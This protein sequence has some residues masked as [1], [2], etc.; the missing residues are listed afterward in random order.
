M[1]IAM[2]LIQADEMVQQQQAYKVQERRN[3]VQAEFEL[4]LTATHECFTIQVPTHWSEA[5]S[6]TI[7][8]AGAAYDYRLN[9]QDWIEIQAFMKVR[10]ITYNIFRI[11][12]RNTG[13][14]GAGT[15]HLL[16]E[17]IKKA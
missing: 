5:N 7:L 12:I 9:E 4:D 11:D 8:P 2:R 17:G 3:T 1:D 16:L 6:F 13:V 14:A 15:L 10:E